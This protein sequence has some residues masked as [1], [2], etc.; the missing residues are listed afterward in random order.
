M[1]KVILAD[2]GFWLGLIDPRDNF[3]NSANEISELID[4]NTILFPW[5]CLYETIST[6]LVRRRQQLLHLEKL[7]SQ[8]FVILI[9]DNDYKMS[10][11][12]SVFENNRRT[13]RAFSLVD[14]VIREIIKDVNVKMDYFVTFNDS[15]FSDVCNARKIE[16][17]NA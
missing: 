4:G 12:S 15:D 9:D 7:L 3:H 14:S 2:T 11:L 5:P 10:A 1:R 13:G 8:S 6:R 16:I 17:L